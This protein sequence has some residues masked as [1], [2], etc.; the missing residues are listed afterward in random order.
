[1]ASGARDYTIMLWDCKSGE[2]LATLVSRANCPY[3]CGLTKQSHSAAMKTG[4]E[5]SSS[6]RMANTYSPRPMTTLSAC[7]N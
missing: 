1:M 4:F 7:G 2:K 6:I 5:Q 3:R